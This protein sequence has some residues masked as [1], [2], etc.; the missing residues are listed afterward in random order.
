MSFTGCLLPLPANGRRHAPAKQKKLLNMAIYNNSE[1]YL[2]DW[3][4]EVKWYCS[5]QAATEKKVMKLPF[6]D[7]GV[8]VKEVLDAL[9]SGDMTAADPTFKKA[10]FL[11]NALEITEHLHVG[12][13][14]LSL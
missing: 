6:G 2:H 14:R 13:S 1:K 5:D 12:T 3:R 9:H 4:G 10:P 11:Y 8:T 7:P